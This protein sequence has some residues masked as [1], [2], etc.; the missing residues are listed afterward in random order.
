M[1]DCQ[2]MSCYV[3]DLQRDEQVFCG[4][5]PVLILVQHKFGKNRRQGGKLTRYFL[6]SLFSEMEESPIK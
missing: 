5:F 3:L 4:T 2:R 1:E 6:W